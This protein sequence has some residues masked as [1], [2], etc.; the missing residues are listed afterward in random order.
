MT[1]SPL[2]AFPVDP[3]AGD[4]SFVDTAANAA[5]AIPENKIASPDLLT[6]K[7]APSIMDSIIESAKVMSPEANLYEA[8][9]KAIREDP[10][11]DPDFDQYAYAKSKASD[12]QY[13]RALPEMMDR[14]QG[15]RSAAAFDQR[16]RLR[17]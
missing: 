17:I 16:H 13:A 1:T 4:T 2:V 15:L 9:R 12:P 3:A 14:L 7:A 11:A 10:A 8:S 6:P 5:V